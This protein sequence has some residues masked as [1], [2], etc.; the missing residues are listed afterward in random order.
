[1]AAT[2]TRYRVDGIDCASCASKIINAVRR[3]P[4]VEDVSVSVAKGNMTVSHD[5]AALL[6]PAILR[7]VNGLG[8]YKATP[9]A[10]HATASNDE[11]VHAHGHDHVSREGH[12]HGPSNGPWYRSRKGLMTIA[13]GAALIAAYGIGRAVPSIAEYAFIAAMLIGLVPIARRAVMAALAGTPFSIEMLM[14]IAA[15][16]A[17]IIG[18]GEEG[19]A[20]VFLFLVGE[21]LEGVAAGAARASIQGLTGLVPKAALLEEN[22]QTRE[23]P[24]DSVAVGAII[25]VRPGDRIAADGE[26][27][28]GESAIDEAPVTG[29]SVPK[30]KR[31]GDAVFA[32]T[33]N[34]DGVLR[35]RVTATA[36]DNTIAR[37][38]KLVEEAQESKAPTERF[39]D[40][41]STYY[42]PAV[43][44]IAALI[45]VLPPLLRGQPWGE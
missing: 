10:G 37:V 23:V 20:V 24:A 42:T 13:S 2:Q 3:V 27:V 35:V 28:D 31:K 25:L 44:A 43:V 33:I 6:E 34:A 30:R 21:L 32:G 39:I 5:E 12:D 18:A 36:A 14:T 45:A 41:F 4:G 29:E 11:H 26:I 16:G 9:M 17:V 38:V 22:G 19:A 1:M 40:R 8:G 15:V 7:Q